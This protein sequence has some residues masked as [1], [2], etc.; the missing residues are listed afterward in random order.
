MSTQTPVAP[1]RGQQ[2][3][4]ALYDVLRDEIISG[5]IQA[6]ERLTERELSLRYGAS[7][8]PVREA[9]HRLHSEG[10]LASNGKSMSVADVTLG[11][12][13]DGFRLRGAILTIVIELVIQR[14]RPEDIDRL[15]IL[16]T[17]LRQAIDEDRIDDAIRLSMAFDKAMFDATHSQSVSRSFDSSNGSPGLVAR[18]LS[19]RDRLLRA[20]AERGAILEAIRDRD[21]ERALAAGRAFVEAGRKHCYETAI[22]AEALKVV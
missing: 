7:R 3:G 10:F 15:S 5:R 9:L 4:R 2:L 16:H 13:M 12:M 11:E 22:A 18:M 6:G 20:T 14:G 8:T 1:A 17:H 19:N 21:V